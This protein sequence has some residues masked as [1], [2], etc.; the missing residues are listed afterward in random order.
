MN[1]YFLLNWIWLLD[2]WANL[3]NFWCQSL[4]GLASLL[5]IILQ[6]SWRTFQPGWS[7]C[8]SPRI[9]VK[10]CWL[11]ADCRHWLSRK[12]CRWLLTYVP[13]LLRFVIIDFVWWSKLRMIGLSTCTQWYSWSSW[14]YQLPQQNFM[15][16]L[17]CHHQI[18]AVPSVYSS[19]L[20]SFDNIGSRRFI[21]L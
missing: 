21:S 4:P 15:G 12:L 18:S 11:F 3:I 9:S 8:T 1:R 17:L 5:Y 14:T 20:T 13:S 6:P 16:L 10:A 2:C 19:I 7:C